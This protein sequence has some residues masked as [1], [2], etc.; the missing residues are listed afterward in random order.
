MAAAGDGE[1]CIF[2][3]AG[4]L[5]ESVSEW[6]AVYHPHSYADAML[7]T[8]ALRANGVTTRLQQCNATRVLF[9]QGG[10]IVQVAADEHA[11]AREVLRQVRGVRTDTEYLEWQ[12]LKHRPQRIGLVLVAVAAG[13]ALAAGMLLHIL[14]DGATAP[15]APKQTAR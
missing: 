15:A 4:L 11:V 6:R 9:G 14:R 8:A 12:A 7:A 5:L 13:A 3:G 1:R 2:C 10:G